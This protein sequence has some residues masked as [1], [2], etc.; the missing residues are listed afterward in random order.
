MTVIRFGAIKKPNSRQVE[1]NSY[2]FININNIFDINF[3]RYTTYAI[4]LKIGTYFGKKRDLLQSNGYV[5]TF[6]RAH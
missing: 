3:L 6:K 5:H 2:I 1:Y 4:A